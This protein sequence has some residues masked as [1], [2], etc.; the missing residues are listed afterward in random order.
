MVK[1]HHAVG[2]V[3]EQGVQLVPLVLHGG[4]RGLK[5][6]SHLVE[7]PVRMPISSVDSH[8]E[9]AV[10][11]SPRPPR[12]APA[13]SFSDGAHHGLGQQEAQQDRDQQ[14]RSP[15]PA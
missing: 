3:E 5:D 4:Q 11:V 15:A 7:V 12:S 10:K 14:A 1:G 2:H 8:G 9:L 6:I 13:V